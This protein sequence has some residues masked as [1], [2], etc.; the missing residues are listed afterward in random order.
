MQA[1]CKQ[2]IYMYI[3]MNV[4]I[5]NGS[6]LAST[7]GVITLHVIII[8]SSSGRGRGCNKLSV[9]LAAVCLCNHLELALALYWHA[10]N[11]CALIVHS[12][13]PVQPH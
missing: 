2:A 10:Q 8:A 1:H 5:H 7:Y 13:I 4:S 11:V 9:A 6:Y 12:L 3:R